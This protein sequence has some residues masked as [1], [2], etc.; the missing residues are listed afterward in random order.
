MSKK[1][2]QV[3]DLRVSFITGEQEFEAV[4][5]I[6][7][8][9]NEGETVGIVGESGSGKS[10]TAR[11]I[12]RLLPSPPSF[13]KDGTIEFQ[14]KNLITQTENQMEAIRGKDISMIFQDP[15]TSTNP[16]IRIG[17]Q[18]AEGIIKHQG[19]SKKKRI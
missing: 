10:V 16:T 2:L 5:G 6:S 7:F 1:L 12:M 4:K 8:H 11:S 17:D 14:G 19:L 15:M 18:I 9:V 3:K 13:L